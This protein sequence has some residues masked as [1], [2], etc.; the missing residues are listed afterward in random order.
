MPPA[1]SLVPS[2]EDAKCVHELD[3]ADVRGLHDDPEFEVEIIK[4][5]YPPPA[6]IFVMSADGANPIPEPPVLR[7]VQVDPPFVD[8]AMPLL[9]IAAI[10]APS[11]DI[12]G[13]YQL[14]LLIEAAA[15][16]LVQLTPEFV[17]R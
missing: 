7:K 6:I 10:R 17:E 3:P 14:P 9:V 16:A 4:P 1:T 11:S 15:V 13:S 5:G 12:K 8:V 2:A